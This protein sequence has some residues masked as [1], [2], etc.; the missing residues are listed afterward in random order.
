MAK[1]AAEISH[2]DEFDYLIVNDRFSDALAALHAI[3]RKGQKPAEKYPGQ[4]AKILAELL[5]KG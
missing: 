2:W 4:H 1:A 5:G 3:I